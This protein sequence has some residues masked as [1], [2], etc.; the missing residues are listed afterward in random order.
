[1]AT[2]CPTFSVETAASLCNLEDI[3]RNLISALASLAAFVLLIMLIFGGFK[4]LTSSG[5]A[6]KLEQ[7]RGTITA[8]I[9]GLLLIVGAYIILRLIEFF[10][11][12]PLTTF[13]IPTK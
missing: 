3:F 4:W 8:A 7:A 13:T 6:K 11:G 9:L 5:D 10:T 1:M 12:L 2:P